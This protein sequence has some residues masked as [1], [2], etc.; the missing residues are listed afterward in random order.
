MTQKSHVS[1]LC[2]M[3]L[4]ENVSRSL[5][6]SP[7]SDRLTVLPKEAEEQLANH[8]SQLESARF[9]CTRA[10][11][12]NLAYKYAKELCQNRR[13]AKTTGAK[14]QAP[15][16]HVLIWHSIVQVHQILVLHLRQTNEGSSCRTTIPAGP[17]NIMKNYDWPSLTKVLINRELRTTKDR[18]WQDTCR[19]ES[20]TSATAIFSA[21][22]QD[23][24]LSYLQLQ[25]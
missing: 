21:S 9:P 25:L 10:A 3:K 20:R 13:C 24:L 7:L 15:K 4:S 5:A 23:H 11:V 18:E 19:V 17:K 16:L 12:R 8:I 2:L 1:G 22:S 14:M 6:H